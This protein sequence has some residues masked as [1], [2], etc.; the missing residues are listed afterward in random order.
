[1]NINRNLIFFTVIFLNCFFNS[2]AQI[3]LT[4][5]VGNELINPWVGSCSQPE[6]WARAFTLSEFGITTDD[7]F[8]IN[9][10]NV[11][12]R[13]SV[14]Q[15]NAK[16]QFNIYSID[17]GFPDTFSESNLIG[18][19]QIEFFPFVS[20]LNPQ[21]ITI[22]FETPV[23]VPANVERI[24][25]EVKKTD[26]TGIGVMNVLLAGT[27]QGSEPAWY[28]G[29]LGYTEYTST[30]IAPLPRPNANL[31]ITA[32]G[33]IVGN[34][35]DYENDCFG[36][37][38]VFELN[39]NEQIESVL[40]DFGD[41]TT[42][43]LL[44]PIHIFENLGVYDISATINVLNSSVVD[45]ID[46][47]IE[48][49]DI[50]QA[51]QISSLI[52]CEE[53]FGSGYSTFDTTNIESQLIPGQ[54]DIVIRYFDELGNELPSPLP[55][56]LS[57]SIPY[58]ETITIRLYNQ[59]NL[60]CYVESSFDVIVNPKPSINTLD[61]IVNCDN[62]SDGFAEFDLTNVPTELINSQSNL[63]VEL[64]DSN[65]NLISVSDYNNFVNLTANQD[66]IKAIVTNSIT[67]CSSE[68]N[69][70][71][72]VNDNP[73]VNQ[74]QIIYGCDDNND[75][76]STYFDTSNV[77]SQ[78][79]NGQTGMTVSYF[80]QRGNQLSNPL[81]NPL[82]NSN[83]FN[84]L[85]IVRVTNTNTTCYTETTLELQTV[86]Q[87]NINQLDN[88]YACD[89]GNGYTEFNTS[90]IEQQL[91]GSQTGLTIQYYDSNN[92]SLPSPLPN[93][94]QN[95]EPY[96]Q[97]IN[98]RVED[99]SNPICYSET[100]FDLIVNQLPEI[101]LEDEYFICNLEPSISLNI[102]Y[103]FNSYNW[104]FED[105]TLIS[106]TNSAEI[107]EEGSYTLTVTQMENGITC[108]NSFDFNLIRSDLPEIQQINYGVLGNNYIEII[109]SGDGN[110]EYS[111]DG[112]N[113]QDSNYFSNIQ[114]GIYAVFVRDKDGCG[115]DSDEVIIID[116]PKFFTPNNDGYND[117]W[118]IKGISE[119][120]NSEIL[121]FDRYGKLLTQL[122]SSDLGWSG[123]Y[124]G[125]KMMSNDYWFRANL[126][127][128]Q[129][130]SGHFSLK[131]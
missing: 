102:N 65:N 53:S 63:F 14:G 47:Q 4:H 28:K 30:D 123:L 68:T 97:T 58:S 60:D 51:N 43:N 109:A 40:W 131:R 9:S 7:E 29:C 48:I 94:F 95:T 45:V 120:P 110:F 11:G 22:D 126:G 130:F 50:P 25:V 105:G 38:T 54:T 108:E 3:T 15:E 91:I 32:N 24:L 76:I 106:G 119:F 67:N 34:R 66:Y 79:L 89:Q 114:G 64:F 101:N 115:E 55:N 61:N 16:F 31:F 84:E 81:P 57:N 71:L 36:N 118:Q 96:S 88:L 103:G 52:T 112:I 20:T 117:L 23:I 19:S 10:G 99:T 26:G 127:N 121:I 39:Y 42:S 27:E 83:P 70:N 93:V 113:Y 122:A 59:N 85:I 128:G 77:D 73:E 124:N 44:N 17:S 98:I 69:V 37:E 87:P 33:E 62:N 18:S 35:I 13:S 12:V 5:N 104:F 129:V 75:G 74:L 100:S 8:Q 78:V 90:N 116:Y 41:G 21:I 86:M 2:F 92:N 6:H 1:M 82:T 125:K 80:D 111:I 72:I 46:K 56:P 107:I 49:F